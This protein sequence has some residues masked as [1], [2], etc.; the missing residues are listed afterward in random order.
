MNQQIFWNKKICHIHKEFNNR[1]TKSDK[2]LMF[3]LRNSTI[4]IDKNFKEILCEYGCPQKLD[5]K[6]LYEYKLNY[7]NNGKNNF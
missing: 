5:V 3:K 2:I 6:H 4:A 1:M 7:L